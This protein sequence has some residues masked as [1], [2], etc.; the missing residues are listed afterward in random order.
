MLLSMRLYFI[1]RSSIGTRREATAA[2]PKNSAMNNFAI[3]YAAKVSLAAEASE[4]SRQ[5]GVGAV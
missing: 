1:G 2:S 5:R 3:F 4:V